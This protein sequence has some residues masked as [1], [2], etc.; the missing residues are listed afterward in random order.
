MDLTGTPETAQRGG[1][2]YT[3][4]LL[5]VGLSILGAGLVTFTKLTHTNPLSPGWV[6][7]A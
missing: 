5:L 4:F 2:V 7:I 1:A 3:V 6:L